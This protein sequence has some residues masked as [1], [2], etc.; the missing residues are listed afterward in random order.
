MHTLDAIN[1]DPTIKLPKL[2]TKSNLSTA[3]KDISF[4]DMLNRNDEL[5]KSAT[6]KAMKY[7][8]GENIPV[9]DVMVSMQNAK[10]SF[11]FAVQVRNKL[12]ESYQEITRMQI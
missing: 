12:V 10:L 6:E 5:Y 3:T 7:A 8:A 4:L 9:H 1:F 11:Q 2:D